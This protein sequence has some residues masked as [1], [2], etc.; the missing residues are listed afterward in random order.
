MRRRLLPVLVLTAACAA[1][2]P[3]PAQTLSARPAIF[4][5]PVLATDPTR[6]ELVLGRTTLASALRIFA[7]ELE[8]DT[9]RVARRHSS[10]PEVLENRT[11]WAAGVRTFEPRYRLDLGDDYYTL[12]FDRNERLIVVATE[13]LPRPVRRDELVARYPTL[14]FQRRWRSGTNWNSDALEAPLGPCVTLTAEVWLKNNMVRELGYMYT[15]PTKPARQG[16]RK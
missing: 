3:C 2:S 5:D 8:E 6:G 12:Y 13:T 15:C 16:V 4:A 1:A 9:V 14:A 7:V 10:N 11:I